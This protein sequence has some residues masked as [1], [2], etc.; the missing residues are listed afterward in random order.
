[1]AGPKQNEPHPFDNFSD[2]RAGYERTTRKRRR[3]PWLLLLLLVVVFFLPNVIAMTGLKQKAIDYALADFNG[4]ITV[5]SASFGWLQP[6]TLKQIEAVDEAG[7]P[8]ATIE[9]VK[10][11]GSLIS[12]LTSSD[13]G[14][15]EVNQPAVW[16]QLRPDGS[17]LEDACAAWLE[18]ADHNDVADSQKSAADDNIR[19]PKV[20]LNINNGTVAIFSMD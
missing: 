15:I 4:R 10:T 16:L 11:S 9:E 14:T 13:Y 8:L 19:L 2:D 17:N 5:K 1:M 3:W 7:R 6:T 12:F 20:E 18:P